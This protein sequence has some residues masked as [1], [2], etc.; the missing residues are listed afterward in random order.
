MIRH[1]GHSATRSRA[2]QE[3]RE[4]AQEVPEDLGRLTGVC[5]PCGRAHG[6]PD[7]RAFCEVCGRERCFAGC[8]HGREE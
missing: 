4:I 7:N 8:D 2:L 6:F 1:I 5:Q 3:R